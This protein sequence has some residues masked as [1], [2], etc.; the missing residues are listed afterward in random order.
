MIRFEKSS[1]DKV[2]SA[3]V[4]FMPTCFWVATWSDTEVS[5]V[6]WVTRVAP[7]VTVYWLGSRIF[8]VSPIFAPSL[9]KLSSYW[10]LML[11][12]KVSFWWRPCVRDGSL[13]RPRPS[14][15]AAGFLRRADYLIAHVGR[16]ALRTAWP[17]SLSG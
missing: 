16:D 2:N 8:S 12:M 4:K 1:I 11:P 15:A 6:S 9:A 13:S 10:R 14:R 3:E 7:L 17:Y 5:E